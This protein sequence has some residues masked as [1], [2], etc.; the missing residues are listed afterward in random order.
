MIS[1]TNS[2]S[3]FLPVSLPPPSFTNLRSILSVSLHLRS[4]CIALFCLSPFS[5][6]LY[7]SFYCVYLSRDPHSPYFATFCL[8]PCSFILC[9][10]PFCLSPFSLAIYTSLYC[11]FLPSLSLS[12]IRSTLSLSLLPHFLYF[13]LFCLSPF[14]LALHTLLYCLSLPSP[15][16]SILRSKNSQVCLNLSYVL[17]KR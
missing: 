13:A 11:V 2:S 16:L 4:L 3:L 9:V 8:S 12:I 14:S 15:L 10:A 7:A 6:A 5:L 1:D 17:S